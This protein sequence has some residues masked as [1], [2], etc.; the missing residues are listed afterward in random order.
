MEFIANPVKHEGETFRGIVEG[1]GDDGDP[2]VLPDDEVPK[3]IVKGDHPDLERQDRVKVRVTKAKHQY[4]F[5]EVVD[6]KTEKVVEKKSSDE[7]YHVAFQM[8]GYD[9][10]SE[11]LPDEAGAEDLKEFLE[12]KLG[13]D[14][15]VERTR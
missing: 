15:S 11:N 7:D 8:F 3:I 12:S 4:M 10:T 2:V 1:F 6:D 13:R 9:F 5:G 14:V